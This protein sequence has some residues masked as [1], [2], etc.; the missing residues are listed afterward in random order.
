MSHR[1]LV[2]VATGPDRYRL[3][4]DPDGGDDAALRRLIAPGANG[5]VDSAGRSMLA[6]GLPFEAILA[7]HLDP[8]E[9]EALVVRGPDGRVTPHRVLPFVLATADG[10]LWGD[11]AGATVAL[12]SGDGVSLDPAYVRGWHH[13]TTETLAEGVDVGLVRPAAAV[14]WL[15][16]AVRRLA[17]DRFECHVL[18]ARV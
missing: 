3:S 16:D 15:E 5:P 1:A 6:R 7:D 11:P 4:L 2:A 10:V 9:H 14:E 8:V 18:S 13:G 17:G 12:R